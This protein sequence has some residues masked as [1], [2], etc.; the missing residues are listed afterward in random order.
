MQICNKNYAWNAS[1][2]K[3]HLLNQCKHRDP[4][5]ISRLK[6]FIKFNNSLKIR[7]NK[8]SVSLNSSGSTDNSF[9]T[10]DSSDPQKPTS[11]SE[12][13][14]KCQ[15]RKND[16]EQRHYDH[17]HSKR[18]KKTVKNYFDTVAL[19]DQQ[20]YDILMA[21]TIY[22]SGL[23]LTLTEN[24]LWIKYFKAIRPSLILPSRNKLS[25]DEV[26]NEMNNKVK[27]LIKKAPAVGI[28]CDGWSNVNSQGVINFIVTTHAPLFV[29]SVATG[30]N[31]HNSDY[32]AQEIN[33]VIHEVDPNKVVG[34]VADNASVMGKSSK[35]V[36]STKPWISSYGCV[37]HILNLFLKDIGSLNS[38]QKLLDVAKNIINEIKSNQIL[39]ATFE[40]IQKDNPDKVSTSLKLPPNTR[41]G[42][43]YLC[44]KSLLV[45]KHNLKNLAVS[46]KAEQYM[47]PLTSKIILEHPETFWFK[48]FNITVILKPI[49]KWISKLE[50]DRPNLSLVSECFYEMKYH[51]IKHVETPVLDAGD[52]E[53]IMKKFEKR[54]AMA[55]RPVHYAANMLDPLFR[56]KNLEPKD[57]D[58]ATDFIHQLA[59]HF[60]LNIEIFTI[61]LR[62]Y[63]DKIG[64]WSKSYISL[65]VIF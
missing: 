6:P 9:I 10:E 19:K 41:F 44:L 25:N 34:L 13:P 58:L 18:A 7:E 37:A 51:L 46:K 63:L 28:Q 24:P 42:A 1:R 38:V 20:H 39:L 40:Q 2:M 17:H 8:L 12:S 55:L 62:K 33:K 57:I 22:A 45:N 14:N 35:I 53:L 21:K 23:P 48:L 56:G 36:T 15:K 49:H 31:S 4:S 3:D 32:I 26:Y 52:N 16:Q 30:T 47:K 65:E 29:K 50:G 11:A 5:V 54:Q 60:N 64:I 61:E 27:E 43:I 59:E